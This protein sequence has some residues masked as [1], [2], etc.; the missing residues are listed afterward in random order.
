MGVAAA[1]TVAA[2]VVGLVGQALIVGRYGAGATLDGFLISLILPALVVV[3]VAGAFELTTPSGSVRA[4]ESPGGPARFRGGV[5]ALGV[6][7][8]C[9]AAGLAMLFLPTLVQLSGAGAN[10]SVRASA[11]A[12]ARIVYPGIALRLVSSALAGLL[13]GEGRITAPVVARLANP[14]SFIA[15]LAVSGSTDVELVAYANLTGDIVECLLMGALVAKSTGA[16]SFARPSS[17][18]V[19]GLG[20]VLP[21]MILVQLVP[22]ADQIFV[23]GIGAGALTTF[24]L[25]VRLTDAARSVLIVP[26]LR[27]SQTKVATAVAT[28]DD[29]ARS[30]VRR[31]G[32]DGL[33]LGVVASL[34][35][36]AVGPLVVMS[37]FENGSFARA[38]SIDTI[39]VLFPLASS[40]IAA[41]LHGFY[42][43]TLIAL[44]RPDITNRYMGLYVLLN[45]VGDAMLIRPF[46]APGVATATTISLAATSI[47]QR[48]HIRRLFSETRTR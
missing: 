38:D 23:A 16:I 34:T 43:R 13:I 4:A 47:G 40:L 30:A 28:S 25:A 37:L 26:F 14:A 1:T 9:S 2:R 3:P 39:T 36:A 27:L 8:G 5:I 10:E 24:S 44:G 41:G 7:F 35:L 32:R 29:V 11:E 17:T 46:G 45:I 22:I 31:F 48:R 12:A 42:G 33:L 18:I 20:A 19:R 6:V 15:F 21:L